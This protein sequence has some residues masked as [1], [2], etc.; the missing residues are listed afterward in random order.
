MAL[1]GC[2]GVATLSRGSMT[3]GHRS[4]G[5]VSLP[6]QP[7]NPSSSRPDE[8]SRRMMSTG[9]N[10]SNDDRFEETYRK[11]YGRVW[12][13]YRSCRVSDDESHDLAQDVFKRL[14]PH[15]ASIRAADP[16]PF[17]KRVVKSVHLNR[18]R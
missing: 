10:G 11:Y 2:H 16:W 9:G 4:L 18:I 13:Y 17:L 5:T 3:R 8:V 1:H 14:C 12:R 6:L 15:W 7:A